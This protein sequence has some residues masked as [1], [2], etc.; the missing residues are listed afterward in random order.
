MLHVPLFG[1]SPP[2]PPPSGV[3]APLRPDD[4]IKL[5]RKAAGLTIEQVAE[6]IASTERNRQD[7]RDLIRMLEKPGVVARYRRSLELLNG[8]FA[9]DPDVYHQLATAPAARHPRIC[10]TCG[11]SQNDPCHLG[12]EYQCRMAYHDADQCTRCDQ[13]GKWS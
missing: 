1:K 6:R 2:P 7:V 8:A 12:D 11:C 13:H 4:Y 10:R 9:F 3:L 5:R